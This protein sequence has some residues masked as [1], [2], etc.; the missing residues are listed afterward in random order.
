MRTPEKQK[1]ANAPEVIANSLHKPLKT[2][3]AKSVLVGPE[4]LEPPTNPL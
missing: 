1:L 4:G 2:F 3:M